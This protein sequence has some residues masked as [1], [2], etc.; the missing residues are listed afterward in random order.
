MIKYLNKLER[1]YGLGKNDIALVFL[2]GLA[3]GLAFG[4]LVGL[5]FGL[6]LGLTFGLAS[7]LTFGLA[8]G[9]TV[10]IGSLISINLISFFSN[11][12]FEPSWLYV[13]MIIGLIFLI[14]EFIFL[15]LDKQKPKKKENKISFTAKRKAIAFLKSSLIVTQ[16]FGLYYLIR[17]LFPSVVNNKEM[18]ID[19]IGCVSIVLIALAIVI[20]LLILSVYGYLKLNSLKYE[21]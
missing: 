18:I 10:G 2:S 3:L 11:Y 1:K 4:L 5:T 21:R 17:I 15:V 16:G 7:G 14:M 12:L 9:L 20:V 8:L 13:L 6:A 19:W